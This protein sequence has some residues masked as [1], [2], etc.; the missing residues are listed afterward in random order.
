MKTENN[1]GNDPVKRLVLRLALPSMA[2]QFVSVL[3]SIV[4]RMFIGN[5]KDI[6]DTALAGVGITGPIVN[7]ISAVAFWIGIGGAPIFSIKMGEKNE[8]G[9][10]Q[11][12]ANC[13]LLIL[14]L[15]GIMTAVALIF[16]DKALLLFGASKATFPFAKEYM[17]IYV[18]GTV[19]A[20]IATG[21]NQFIICQGF[22]KVGMK[23]VL[24]GA[25]LNIAL[26]PIF[27]FA[28]H[29]GV[30]GAALATIVSQCAS[31][32]Y[33]LRFLFSDRVP[34]K[35]TFGTYSFHIMRSVLTIGLAP[36]LIVAFDNLLII[37]LN[38]VLQQYGGAERGDMLV[39][40]ATI[41]QSFMLMVTM[42]LGGLTGGTQ[43]ILG[44]NYGARRVDRIKEAMKH[45]LILGIIFTAIMFLL[46]RFVPQY[47][48]LLFTGNEE[49][50]TF[51][52]WAIPIY[53]AGVIPLAIQYTVVDG[54]TGMGIVRIAMPL[55][56][57]RKAIYF[58]FIFLFPMLWGAE[59]VF[60][61]EPV[62]D[63]IAA[64]AS[65]SVYFLI[66]RKILKKRESLA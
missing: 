41:T 14:I 1:L 46:A 15:S 30:K 11:V 24:I 10:K 36:F 56:F 13:F 51:C 27:I 50:I 19:F 40:C 5:I 2:A 28:F 48:A 9:A 57:F 32:C 38:T 58:L 35:I 60:Y 43:A 39:T 47:F 18:L 52:K 23:S 64:I 4:D 22:A 7:L 16:R 62:V 61:N 12:L 59:A 25:V 31:A 33:V 17:T 53:T 20:L 37:S 3:Y 21:M 49:Y 55:S 34:V 6:G 65:S 42:P 8:S 63:I 66:G 44:F 54:F 26:D 45:I 29:M